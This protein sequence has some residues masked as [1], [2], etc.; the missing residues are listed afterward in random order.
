MRGSVAAWVL[1][2]LRLALTAGGW[3]AVSTS[4][5]M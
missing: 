4:T 2:L 3:T 5:A 1:Y